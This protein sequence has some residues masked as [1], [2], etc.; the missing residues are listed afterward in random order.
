[1]TDTNSL[2][3]SFSVILF[4]GFLSLLFRSD[5]IA[6]DFGVHDHDAVLVPLAVFIIAPVDGGIFYPALGVCRVDYQLHIPV[7]DS[8]NLA[9]SCGSNRVKAVAIFAIHHA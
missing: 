2:I 4:L 9:A 7:E 8:G 5:L 1:M 6:V 3:M